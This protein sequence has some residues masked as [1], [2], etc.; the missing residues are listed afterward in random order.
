MREH[1]PEAIQR[2]IPRRAGAFT[3]FKRA[4]G[5]FMDD[6]VM[7]EAA[8]VTFYAMLALFPAI[9]ALISLYGLI[10]D[11]TTL[12]TQMQSM[13]GLIPGGGIDLI[14]D[15]IKSVTSKPP[16]ALGIGFAIGL[17]TSLWS[18]NAG[19]KAFLDALNMVYHEKETRSYV[20]V[21]LI[22]FCFTIGIILFLVLALGAVVVVPI[23]LNDV[24]LGKYAKLLLDLARW[25]VLLVM[26]AVALSFF[27]H[28]GPNR[29]QPRWS[30]ISWGTVMAALLWVVASFGFSYYVANFGS[31]NKTYGSLGAAMGF[32]T[33]IWVSAMVVLFGAEINAAIERH[34]QAR[35]AVSIKA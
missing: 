26:L 2:A 14:T 13:A 8:G 9:G 6:R 4:A 21:T 17:A 34:A 1:H 18:A 28:Y 35:A 29:K 10:A 20:K 33:W 32:M 27:Y 24:G 3:I 16:Q 22:S 5:G 11:P 12:Y 19:V 7:A 25:P 15:Q 30:W 23:V 31:Y